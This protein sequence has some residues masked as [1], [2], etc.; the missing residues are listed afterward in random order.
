VVVC[1]G[2]PRKTHTVG[3]GV[4]CMITT[5]VTLHL[6][7]FSNKTKKYMNMTGMVLHAYNPSTWAA[8]MIGLRVR[9]VW[10]QKKKKVLV[11]IHVY[12]H[13]YQ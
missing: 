7:T 6:C 4:K 11:Y 3:N 5:Y 13:T 12:I 2:N 10:A 9:T 1:Y 8:D